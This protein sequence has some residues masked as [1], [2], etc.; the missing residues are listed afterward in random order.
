MDARGWWRC[1]KQ[2]F[3]SNL[4]RSFQHYNNIPII[5]GREK[6]G[7]RRRIRGNLRGSF[8][9]QHHIL[10]SISSTTGQTHLHG[11]SR[12]VCL[13]S[14][15]SPSPLPLL[16]FFYPSVSGLSLCWGIIFSHCENIKMYSKSVIK[17]RF[18]KLRAHHRITIRHVTLTGL[19]P[20]SF[21]ASVG[22]PFL[23]SSSAAAT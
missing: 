8:I 22:S 5:S 13:R 12:P 14:L 18:S 6:V 11:H 3:H 17:K 9:P 4:N 16:D 7:T 19:F 2:Q 15:S 10:L 20:F 21:V 1:C 23:P